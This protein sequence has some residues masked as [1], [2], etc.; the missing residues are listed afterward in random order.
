MKNTTIIIK[1]LNRLYKNSPV[2][3]IY[4]TLNKDN[5]VEEYTKGKNGWSY[6]KTSTIEEHNSKCSCLPIIKF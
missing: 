4:H 5:K 1:G 2:G 6:S 3:E